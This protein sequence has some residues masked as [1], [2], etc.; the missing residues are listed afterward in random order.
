MNSK[1]LSRNQ[2][3]I[4]RKVL[5]LKNNIITRDDHNDVKQ[6]YFP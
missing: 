6:S 3:P 1:E 2:S 4:K 5:K